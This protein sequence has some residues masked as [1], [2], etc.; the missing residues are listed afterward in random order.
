MQLGLR[1]TMLMKT[2]QSTKRN[3]HTELRELFENQIYYFKVKSM[4]PF[5]KEGKESGTQNLQLWH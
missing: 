5:S 1:T 2:M 4:M 3:T